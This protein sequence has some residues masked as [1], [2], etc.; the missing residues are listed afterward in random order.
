M[1]LPYFH[2]DAFSDVPF[3][4]NPA[5]VFVLKEWLPVDIMQSIAAEFNLSETVFSVLEGEHYHI[6]W[7]TPETEVA[8]CGHATLA[9]AHVLLQHLGID[10][11]IIKFSSQSGIL[12]TKYENDLYTLDFPTAMPQEVPPPDHLDQMLGAE[13]LYTY[14][15][16]KLLAV[17]KDE[18]AVESV[19]PDFQALAQLE[20]SAVC[21]TAP[22][23]TPGIDFVCR[24]FAPANGINEDPVT[25]S[26]Y[27]ML[28]PFYA[29]N[30]G[31]IEFSARQLSKR[32]GD[33]KLKYLNNR[34]LISGKAKT[35]MAG[36]F[37]LEI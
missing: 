18:Q 32:G 24:F 15:T 30:T 6:R 11:S 19:K 33:L 4:G 29:I 10:A 22:A 20:Y 3:K 1:E 8:L 35:V 26:A 27:A 14:A 5:A 31:R 28:T 36:T 16:D 12:S 37:F 9:T 17:L 23:S 2:V 21:I 34:I 25:G 7:F 13:V